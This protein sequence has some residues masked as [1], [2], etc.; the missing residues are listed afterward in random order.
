MIDYF[1]LYNI[2]TNILDNTTI[3]WIINTGNN[4]TE[5]AWTIRPYLL[6]ESEF[7]KINPILDWF[8]QY[9]LYPGYAAIIMTPANSVCKTHVDDKA[10]I[11]NKKERRTAINFPIQGNWFTST[12]NYME[13][14][15]N[16]VILETIYLDTPTCW[17]VT[18]PHRIDN[19]NCKLNR[20]TLSFSFYE[21]VQEIHDKLF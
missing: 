12:F 13:N 2:S 3:K 19:S 5:P 6:K 8:K 21:S 10:K 7:D 1:K 14:I 18:K 16:D 20:I 15:D 17:N 9:N 11:V 4:I